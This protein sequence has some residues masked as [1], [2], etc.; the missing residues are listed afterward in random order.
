[1]S[2]QVPDPKWLAGPDYYVKPDG[3]WISR[4]RA[5]EIICEDGDKMLAVIDDLDLWDEVAELLDGRLADATDKQ[6][7]EW[8]GKMIHDE[9]GGL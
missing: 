7:A 9:D 5:A 3:K 2:E 6:L 4:G 8:S 1:M